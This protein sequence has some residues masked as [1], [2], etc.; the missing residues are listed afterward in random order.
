MM[1]QFFA[2]LPYGSNSV[3][4]HCS[5]LD[6]SG[7][8][9]VQVVSSRNVYQSFDLQVKNHECFIKLMA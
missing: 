6:L 5:L 8:C 9:Y 3:S 4:V 2:S 1:G 7:V